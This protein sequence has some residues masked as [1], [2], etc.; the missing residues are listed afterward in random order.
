MTGFRIG[1][2]STETG[3]N[4]ETI[5]FYEKIGLMPKPP[6]TEGGRRLYDAGGVTRLIFIRRARE[7]G[8][9]IDDIRGFL[10][11]NDHQPTCAEIYKTASRHRAVIRNKI[12]DLK[13][14]DRRLS[15]MMAACTQSE[16]PDCAV[17]DALLA[18][19]SAK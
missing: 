14:L 7:L 19:R 17:I 13:R 10:G 18:P 9:S 4:I 3:V 6:R 15:V 5:R 12:A 11:L 2:L 16:K 1:R 8:F